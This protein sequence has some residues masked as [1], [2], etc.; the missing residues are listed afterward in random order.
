MISQETFNIIM[1]DD[2]ILTTSIGTEN[3]NV[4]IAESFVI[5]IGGNMTKSI[6]DTNYNNIV[7]T[8]EYIDCGTF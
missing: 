4:S 8:C 2:S 7:D 1:T 6:Y 3:I 5:E